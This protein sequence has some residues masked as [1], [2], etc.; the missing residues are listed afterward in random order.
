MTGLIALVA[1][2]E[3]TVTPWRPI[4]V[5][6]ELAT[7]EADKAEVRL[8]KVL[9]VRLGADL[10]HQAGQADQRDQRRQAEK[11]AKKRKAE[12]MI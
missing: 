2:A 12:E 11:L 5:G 8:Q 1:R 10:G 7:G 3:T 6:V 9:A 4:F